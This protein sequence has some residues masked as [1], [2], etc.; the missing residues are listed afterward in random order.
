MTVLHSWHLQPHVNEMFSHKPLLLQM[1]M[2]K[3]LG[4]EINTDTNNIVHAID[5][6][7]SLM[8]CF[9]FP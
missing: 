2:S 4:E 9:N 1:E 8:T 6:P 5:H 7:K 3:D